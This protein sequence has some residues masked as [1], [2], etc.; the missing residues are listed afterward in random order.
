MT[1]PNGPPDRNFGNMTDN[2]TMPGPGNANMTAYGNMT[3][4][5]KDRMTAG[6][7]TFCHPPLDGN[8]T[9]TGNWTAPD[10]MTM[11]QPGGEN[12]TTIPGGN[13]TVPKPADGNVTPPQDQNG[14]NA[15]AGA[16]SGQQQGSVNQAQSQD[17][18]D[19]D[20]IATFLKWL[21]GQTGI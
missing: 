16:Q 7:M 5:G 6:N 15:G 12:S 8:T 17:L 18:K 20:L 3:W 19:S 13:I 21:K 11:C 14:N 10:N 4:H 2:M 9:P 1:E